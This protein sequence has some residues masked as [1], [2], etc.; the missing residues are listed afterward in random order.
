MMKTKVFNLIGKNGKTVPLVA[1]EDI[2]FPTQHLQDFKSYCGAGDGIGDYIVPETMFFLKTSAACYI[3][4]R[5]WEQADGSWEDFHY[6]NSVFI[7][8]L[9]SI[10]SYQSKSTILKHMRMYRAVTYFNAV[11]SIGAGIY[12]AKHSKKIVETVNE[13]IV[14]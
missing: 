3:H 7:H 10:I 4:D 6:A 12:V 14:A 13:K 2:K 8:N 11:D 5:M 9:I 1:P